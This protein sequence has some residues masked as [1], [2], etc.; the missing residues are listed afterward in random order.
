LNNPKTD[1]GNKTIKKGNTYLKYSGI[2][3]QLAAL[4][5][6]AIFL[7]KKLDSL[8]SLSKPYFT[9]LLVLLF[10]SAFLYKLYLDLSKKD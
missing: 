2:A 7:G 9:I 10:F 5:F 1:S 6:L 3:F 8:F 4:I